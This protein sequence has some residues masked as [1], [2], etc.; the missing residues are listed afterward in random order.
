LPDKH[1]RIGDT[2][3]ARGIGSLV[4]GRRVIL[5]SLTGWLGPLMMADED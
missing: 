2:G 5:P 3:N 4:L 1:S